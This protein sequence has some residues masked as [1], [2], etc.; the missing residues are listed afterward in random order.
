MDYFAL[1]HA[2]KRVYNQ[3]ITSRRRAHWRRIEVHLLTLDGQFVR[4]L[5][6]KF[7]N[8]QVTIDTD[9]TPS[10]TLQLQLI[11]Q[12][13]ALVFDPSSAGEMPLH[14][15]YQLRVIDA[16]LIPG[17]DNRWID[18]TVFTGPIRSF[19]RQG[20]LVSLTADGTER[21][22]MGTVRKAHAWLRKTRITTVIT[23]LLTLAGARAIE[24]PDL[25]ETTAVHVHVGTKKVK[26][27]GHEVTHKKRRVRGFNVHR[28]DT[29]WDKC[30]TLSQGVN[31][32]L[33]ADSY[34]VF[35]L[36][37]H[38][39]RPVFHFNG[40]ILMGDVELNRPPNEGP[41]TWVV[42]GAKPKGS[43]KQVSSGLVGFPN[44]FPL[45]AYGLAW[46]GEPAQI[47]D[48]TSNPHL[49]TIKACRRV[50]LRKRDRAMA[51]TAEAT[52]DAVPIPWLAVNEREMV[53][54][55]ASWGV[56]SVIINQ[57]TYPLTMDESPMTVGAAKRAEPRMRRNGAE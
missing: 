15:K 21:L 5:T 20:P 33:Y 52:F 24:I 2:E 32:H 29:Y 54:A 6:P 17:L 47:L 31:R 42:T 48:E 37:P 44:A 23:G 3:T 16:R 55:Q 41:N 35:K 22:A 19:N 13:R 46:H 39:E 40:D 30:V 27:H 34:G 38:A 4:A 11:D 51:V 26:K 43:K 8:G 49:T 36:R 1:T 56:P 28:S 45:S 7:Y 53:T 12:S 50:A 14:R 9:Q 25:P 18:V 57:L 10:R